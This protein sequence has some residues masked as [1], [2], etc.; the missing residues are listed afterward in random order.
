M[1][2]MAQEVSKQTIKEKLYELLKQS[3]HTNNNPTTLAAQLNISLSYVC[4]I[5]RNGELKGEL[6]KTKT[7]TKVFYSLVEISNEVQH[8]N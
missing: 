3:E 5:L 8:G 6:T 2:L 1:I 7:G 4:Q